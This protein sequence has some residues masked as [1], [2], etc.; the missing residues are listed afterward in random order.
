MPNSV[1]PK[2]NCKDA[3]FLH[4]I[5]EKK[6][7]DACPTVNITNGAT[8]YLD[9]VQEDDFIDLK[10]NTTSLIKGCDPFRRS[11]VSMKVLIE[12]KN[13]DEKEYQFYEKAIYT[14]FR[15]YSTGETWV[16]CVSHY[17]R[18][19]KPHVFDQLIEASTIINENAKNKLIKFIQCASQD[20]WW[21]HSLEY[22][23]YENAPLHFRCKL[24]L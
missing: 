6:L 8:D 4:D 2:V 12:S 9:L 24:Y 17:T 10:G 20:N 22:T 1:L 7:L 14:V 16:M 3:V 21:E 23:L 11:Y 13:K 19:S 15:R 5:F 18:G